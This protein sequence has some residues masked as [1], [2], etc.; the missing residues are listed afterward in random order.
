[1]ISKRT[2]EKY[3]REAL[4]RIGKWPSE[5]PIT[6]LANMNMQ[7]IKLTQELLDQ[8]LLRKEDPKLDH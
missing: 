5:I 8:H 2:L 4:N 7:I 3:R 6:D 1:M